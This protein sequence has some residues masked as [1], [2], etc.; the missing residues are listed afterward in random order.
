MA[1]EEKKELQARYEEL[2]EKKAFA[3]WDVDKL[4]ELI[5]D[6]EQTPEPTKDEVKTTSTKC[7]VMD[8]E[9]DT[10]E[11][12]EFVLQRRKEA[13]HNIPTTARVWDEGT[14]SIREIRY[15]RTEESPY[16]DQQSV[17]SKVERE[18]IRFAS[19]IL[20]VRGTEVAKIR[21]LL[22][23]DAN[24]DKEKILHNNAPIKNL[25]RL[26]DK[27]AEKTA[28]IE[29]ARN[30]IKAGNIIND[31][32]PEELKNFMRSRFSISGEDNHILTQAFSKSKDYATL[33][34]TDFT[35]PKH[36]IKALVQQAEE[37]GLIKVEGSDIKYTQTSALI[38]T[39]DKDRFSFDESLTRWILA[40]DKEA[41]EFLSV[42]EGKL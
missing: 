4:K 31:A 33:F 18:L 42:L 35:N 28:E 6:K 16:V 32:K 39:F 21:Y 40:G 30:V 24:G 36:R 34:I 17:D 8:F 10:D 11:V 3:G 20:A 1:Q 7:P 27:T 13:K 14:K 5:A 26:R 23:Y 19:E 9:I 25:Y 22:A 15:C 12:Y 2:Y 37:K 29:N 41:K 38:T